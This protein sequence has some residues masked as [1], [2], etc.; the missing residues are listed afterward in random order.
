[1]SSTNKQTPPYV[2]TISRQ[3]GSGGAFLGRKL[4][5]E[6]DIAYADREILERAA[7]V[8]EVRAEEIEQREERVP[9]LMESVFQ[10]FTFGAPEINHIP[11]LRVPSYEELREA[12][13]TVITEIASVRSAVI[14][15][16]GGFHFLKGYARHLSVFLHADTEFRLRRVQELYSLTA[17]DGL[18]AIHESDVARSRYLRDLTGRTWTDAA[19]YDICLCTSS[20]GLMLAERTLLELAR[21]RFRVGAKHESA[22]KRS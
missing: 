10:S 19:Q 17:Q 22:G 9:S 1:M 20:L 12:E 18:R 6:L 11:P 21:T 16:R 3:L 5:T 13:T 15:G 8:L 7:E 4:A 2:I 14:V